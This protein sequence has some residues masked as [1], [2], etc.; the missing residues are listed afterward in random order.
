[1]YDVERYLRIRSAYSPSFLPDGSLVYL[2]DATGATQAWRL[3]GPMRWQS[4][5]TFGD[6]PISFA[7]A[8]PEREEIVYGR[9]EGGNE[10]TQLFRVGASGEDEAALTDEPEAKHRWGGWAHDGERFAF[11][12]NRRDERVFDVYVQ[13]RDEDEPQLVCETEGWYS[14]VGWSPDDTV[15]AVREARSNFDHDVYTVDVDGGELERVTDSDGKARYRSV[16]WSPDGDALYLVTD[17]GDA[18]TMYLGRLDVS[19]GNVDTVVE[20]GDW[21]VAGVSVDDETGR[22]VY[23]RNVEGYTDLHAAEIRDGELHELPTPDLPDGVAG[24]T[25]FGPEGERFAVTVTGRRRN[26]NI[27]V[28]EFETGEATRW[29]DATTAG[30]PPETFV[31]PEVIRY[32]SFDG[33]IVPALFSTPEDAEPPHPVIVDIHGGPESQRRPSFSGLRQYLLASGYALFEPNVRGSTGYGREYTTLDDRRSRMD[34]VR[35][36][37]AALDHLAE[38]EEVDENRVAAYG[39]SYGGFVVLAALAEY[40]ERWAA[41]VDVVGIANFVT[42][43]ENTGEWR[44]ELREAEYGSLDEDRDFLERISPVNNADSIR[45]PLLV[46]HGANDPRVPLEEAEQIANEVRNN[47][48]VETLVFE[49]EGHGFSKRDNRIEA[50]STMVEFLDN[51]V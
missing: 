30:V 42:F 5:I 24:G 9:D 51:H 26:A 25:S 35:D 10:R 38:R 50:Y 3:D 36:I 11:A 29:T 1:V 47:A 41:G 23:G 46:M 31:G 22:V 15:L 28:V 39:G 14:V 45:A 34:A 6:E 48:P 18:D 17:E 43:L 19:S 4:Q 16:N 40:P 27:Y 32:N 8:S 33:L 7:A 37:G 20:G 49:D 12:S 13:G 44:R 2:N 21:N